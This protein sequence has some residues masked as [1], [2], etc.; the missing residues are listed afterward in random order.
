MLIASAAFI[1]SNSSPDSGSRILPIT[2]TTKSKPDYIT[3]DILCKMKKR[4]VAFRVAARSKKPDDL[5]LAK[6]LRQEVTRELRAAKRKY[7]L[8]QIDLAQGNSNKFW[9]VI[10]KLFLSKSVVP[11]DQVWDDSNELLITGF[12][13]AEYINNYFLYSQPKTYKQTRPITIKW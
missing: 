7:I 10:N 1:P 12:E 3:D 6:T 9:D 11:I 5:K 13:A 2:F 4:D 8:L